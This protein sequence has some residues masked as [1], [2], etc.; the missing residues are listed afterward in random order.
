SPIIPS[1]L[2][3][4]LLKGKSHTSIFSATFSTRSRFPIDIAKMPSQTFF[5]NVEDF[6]FTNSH[7]RNRVTTIHA[8]TRLAQSIGVDLLGFRNTDEFFDWLEGPGVAPFWEEFNTN[9]LSRG[10]L[11]DPRV[12][13]DTILDFAVTLPSHE[14]HGYAGSDSDIPCPGNRPSWIPEQHYYRFLMQVV[15]QRNILEPSNTDTWPYFDSDVVRDVEMAG[16]H[17]AWY[18]LGFLIAREQIRTR[19]RSPSPSLAPRTPSPRHSQLDE[20]PDTTPEL[21]MRRGAM[22]LRPGRPHVS[23]RVGTV[24]RPPL[25]A[26]SPERAGELESD[27]DEDYDED[28]DEDDEADDEEAARLLVVIPNLSQEVRNQMAAMFESLSAAEEGQ[29][30]GEEPASLRPPVPSTTIRPTRGMLDDD[31][32]DLEYPPPGLVSNAPPP[33]ANPN[34]GPN[35]RNNMFNVV[36]SNLASGSRPPATLPP[37]RPAAPPPRAAMTYTIPDLSTLNFGMYQIVVD[38]AAALQRLPSLSP[39][40]PVLATNI[41]DVLGP[42]GGIPFSPVIGNVLVMP[43]ETGGNAVARTPIRARNANSDWVYLYYGDNGVLI[44]IVQHGPSGAPRP[45]PPPGTPGDLSTLD[46]SMYQNVVDYV[47]A[48]QRL[49]SLSPSMP[50]L[51]TNIGDVLG[52]VGGIPFSPVIGEVLVMPPETGGNAVPRTPIRGR[53]V[54]GNWVYVYYGDDGV[55]ISVVRYGPSGAP[56]PGPAP[57]SSGGGWGGLGLR[58]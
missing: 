42:V 11:R 27:D 53:L 16:G 34:P 51:A 29:G 13:W 22:P 15:W 38:Y 4:H 18:V 40:M 32:D 44:S 54:D 14:H 37:V 20:S 8:I 7:A 12:E 2:H 25:H 57:G 50:V 23:F 1:Q 41:G 43:P 47:A 17:Q 36:P 52:P 33:I 58:G 9:F 24:R 30:P 21:S 6:H 5:D 49:P 45:G 48:L 39:P 56:P 10:H 19:S 26:L 3:P 31:D 28:Y 46:I 35:S 55:L